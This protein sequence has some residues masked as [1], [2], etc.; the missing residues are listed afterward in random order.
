MEPPIASPTITPVPKAAL[1]SADKTT[2]MTTP[3][4]QENNSPQNPS[5][6]ADR[7]EMQIRCFKPVEARLKAGIRAEVEARDA[8]DE[9]LARFG[10]QPTLPT[11]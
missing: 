8:P 7:H 10:L 11:S 4:R 1:V 9:F 3:S 5:S 2:T 6:S